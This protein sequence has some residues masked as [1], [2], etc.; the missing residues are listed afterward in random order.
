[1]FTVLPTKIHSTQSNDDGTFSL[2]IDIS[3]LDGDE[4]FDHMTTDPAV[5]IQE[6]HVYW[7]DGK[8]VTLELIVASWAN[9]EVGKEIR[10]EVLA[11]INPDP[12][13][14]LNGETSRLSSA[15]ASCALRRP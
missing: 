5:G 10:L 11:R 14:R 12:T 3:E 13:R 6:W 9:A 4:H 2:F 7:K 15:A 1:M 8:P